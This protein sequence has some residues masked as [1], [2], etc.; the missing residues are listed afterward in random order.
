MDHKVAKSK[1]SPIESIPEFLVG[2]FRASGKTVCLIGLIFGQPQS[3][4]VRDEI[5][6]RIP[7]WHQRTA[8]NIELFCVGFSSKNN[9][10]F[11]SA[12]F[13]SAIGWLERHSRW[14]YSGETDL[15][16]M[17]AVFSNE[18][19]T[20][21]L[22]YSSAVVLTLERALESKAIPSVPALVEDLV[23]FAEQ[24]EGTDPSWGFSD[25]QGK[26]VSMSALKEVLLSLL[27][28]SVRS[29]ARKAFQFVV[30]DLSA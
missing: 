15:I 9:Q 3:N 19:Q 8:R 14:R 17:N 1:R 18:L 6:P 13:L 2:K 25:A 20:V 10:R 26:R 21:I 11:D 30:R 29:E 27:P 12:T 4:L 7:Y 5:I 16:L 28:K 23:A 24:Y 22:D